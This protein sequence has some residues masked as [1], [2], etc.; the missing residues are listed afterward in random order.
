MFK[1]ILFSM[2]AVA[3]MATGVLAD[4]F[5]DVAGLKAGS[6]SDAAISIDDGSNLNLDIDGLASAATGEK[7][8]KAIEACFR[9]FGYGNCGYNYGCYNYGYNCYS[10]CYTYYQPT[11]YCYRPVCYYQSYS[12]CYP[13]YSY[14]GCY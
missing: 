13:T 10:P 7:S 3:L 14:W 6:I 2:V 5:S 9:S 12:Y 1:K 4:D 11:V 8:D